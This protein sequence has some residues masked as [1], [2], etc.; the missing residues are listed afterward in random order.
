[1]L[2][3]NIG[4]SLYTENCYNTLV[5]GE[6]KVVLNSSISYGTPLPAALTP[7]VS[8]DTLTYTVPNFEYVNYSTDFGFTV[9]T[10]NTAVVNENI[11][12]Q[13]FVKTIAG[14]T[15]VNLQE[16]KF[17]FA[18][19]TT[20][21]TNY[22][23]VNPINKI[24]EYP[25]NGWLT[26]TIYYQN[27][28][29]TVAQDLKII[30]KLDS[31]LDLSTFELLTVSDTPLVQLRNNEA[32]FIFRNLNLPTSSMDEEGSKGYVSFRIKMNPAVSIYAVIKNKA[33]VF[34]NHNSAINT[35]TTSTAFCHVQPTNISAT[36]CYGDTLNYHGQSLTQPGNY[37]ANLPAS[38][39]CDTSETLTLNFLPNYNHSFNQAIC[40]GDSILFDGLYRHIAGTY[41]ANYTSITGC[42]SVQ[43]LHLYTFAPIIH[44]V[45]QTIC[46]N[47]IFYFGGQQLTQSGNYTATFNSYSGCDSIVHLSLVV[48]Q[49]PSPVS[50]NESI[51]PGEVYYFY[52]VPHTVSGI[53]SAN[54]TAANGCDSLVT[55]HLYVSP[56]NTILN[57]HICENDS[58]TFGGMNLSA[59][60][61]YHDTLTTSSGCDSILTLNLTVDTIDN[62]VQQIDNT[63]VVNTNGNVQWIN[64][65]TLLPVIGATQSTF[66]PAYNG[67]FAAVIFEGNCTD[68][69]SC[70][71]YPSGIDNYENEFADVAIY[72]NPFEDQLTIMSKLAVGNLQLAEIKITDVLGREMF[73]IKNNRESQVINLS[74]L[75]AGIYFVSISNEDFRVTRKIIKQ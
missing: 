51:C 47:D 45:L 12:F 50:Y 73:L 66:L 8:G 24:A 68:T 54:F 22:K 6:I 16:A 2:A 60:G 9:V 5:Y 4:E 11:C 72:P 61:V 3:G 58:Y 37:T 28:G 13:V 35:N 38:N 64:C 29:S 46:T 71:V 65:N 1:M 7:S 43:E 62:S 53:W 20:P 14:I 49:A 21:V 10:N 70:V 39:G 15:I 27:T 19:S 56:L 57:Q 75:S 63:L 52:G 41:T 17:C 25:Y 55:L 31:D 74:S 18:V 59:T 44:S 48:L 40:E 32:S 34:F 42:D 30:D 67:V 26:Y 23:E 69:T 33:S 36:I